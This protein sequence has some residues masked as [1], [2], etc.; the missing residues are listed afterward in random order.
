M[1]AAAL[2]FY[3]VHQTHIY[4]TH[5]SCDCF[6]LLLSLQHHLKTLKPTLNRQLP[7]FEL[8]DSEYIERPNTANMNMS[9]NEVVAGVCDAGMGPMLG[10]WRTQQQ[11]SGSRP[12]STSMTQG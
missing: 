5:L 12:A 9:G 11:V 2:R 1:K 6:A 4:F 10:C 7:K 3:Q 8:C